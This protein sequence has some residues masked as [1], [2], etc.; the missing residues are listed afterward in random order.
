MGSSPRPPVDIVPVFATCPR[1]SNGFRGTVS[2]RADRPRYRRNRCAWC[3]VEVLL[4][5][6]LL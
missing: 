4:D 1:C 5:R 3:D 6:D 2:W